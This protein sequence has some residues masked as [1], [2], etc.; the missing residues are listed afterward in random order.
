M[1]QKFIYTRHKLNR[2]VRDFIGCTNGDYSVFSEYNFKFDSQFV[3]GDLF[4][5]L[6]KSN[7]KYEDLSFSQNEI[8]EIILRCRLLRSFDY[9]RAI[10]FVAAAEMVVDEFIQKAK[11]SLFVAPRID[12]F[13]LDILERK[14]RRNGV[15]YL[16]VWRSAFLKDKFF[17]TNR[18]EVHKVYNPHVQECE[19]L[20]NVVGD[21]KFR[22]TSLSQ[23]EYTIP[24]LLQKHVKRISRDIALE[25]IRLL[26]P[27]NCGY[28]EMATGFHVD[29]Y[30][31]PI[32]CWFAKFTPIEE[33]R[34][35]LDLPNRKT[36]FIALQVNPE[37]TIDYYSKNVNYINI[38]LTLL[39]CV[40][41]FLAEG[42]KV[43]IKDHPNMFGRRSFRF[44][45]QLVALDNVHLAEYSVT[46]NEILSK[47]DAVFTWSGTVAVQAYFNSI[48]SITICSPY[49]TDVPGFF[50][51][52]TNNQICDAANSIMNFD[53][54]NIISHEHKLEL[55]RTV[56]ST[57]KPGKVFTHDSQQPDA[58]PFADWLNSLD[59]KYIENLLLPHD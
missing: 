20:I 39:E 51:V 21:I 50:Q 30:N 47:C 8:N 38:E 6:L 11:P 41:A 25:G 16:G 3:F 32:S 40:K 43:I 35:L 10:D 7:V 49:T 54:K 48:P 37:S 5:R 59:Q 15:K 13:F 42:F 14:L 12:T 46:S 36:I 28:R 44:I 56:L 57:H 45:N 55:A 53:Y 1:S 19:N 34:K 22:A 18:G 58:K 29:D 23:A 33:I 26:G 24:H 27:L 31:V 4:Q 9:S 17:V 52:N 2:Y